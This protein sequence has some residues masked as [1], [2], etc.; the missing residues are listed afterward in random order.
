MLSVFI[1]VVFFFTPGDSDDGG[2]QYV[3]HSKAFESQAACMSQI[4]LVTA[5]LLK[6]NINQASVSCQEFIPDDNNFGDIS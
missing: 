5:N 1:L 3:V 2:G 6:Q 4:K